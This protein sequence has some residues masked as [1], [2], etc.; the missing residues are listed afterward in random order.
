MIMNLIKRN[1]QEP[2]ISEKDAL[3]VFY[4]AGRS[5]RQPVHPEVLRDSIHNPELR[6]KV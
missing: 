1:T 5:F 2:G 6:I 4:R 3:V